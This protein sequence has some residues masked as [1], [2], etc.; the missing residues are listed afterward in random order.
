MKLSRRDALRAGGGLFAGLSLAGCIEE[1]VTNQRTIVESSGTWAL[2]SESTDAAFDLVEFENYAE[3]MASRYDSSGV[4]GLEAEAT[5]GFE[6]A[7]VQRF[8]ITRRTPGDPG[9]TE[10]SLDPEDVDPDAPLL[11]S[12]ACVAIYDLGGGRRRYWLWSAADSTEGRLV[13]DV[14][15]SDISVGIRVREGALTDAADP[16]VA[17]DEASVNLGTPPSGSFPLR[18]G[19]LRSTRITGAEGIYRIEW[20][21]ELDGIQS[22]N[23]VCETESPESHRFFWD[24]SLGYSYEETV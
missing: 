4:W 21:G 1:R 9:G 16:A 19:S 17:G 15:V 20:G 12:N 3:R 23:G 6:T 14:E 7:Y 2:S 13:R 22:V 8:A 24:T 11:V 18:G 5:D 10:T